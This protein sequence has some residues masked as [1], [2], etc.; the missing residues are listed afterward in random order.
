MPALGRLVQHDP[1]SRDFPA[2]R[3][4]LR[5]TVHKRHA[6]PFNQGAL[7]SCTAHAAFGLMVTEPF[8][9]PGFPHAEKDMIR[10]YEWQTVHDGLPGTYPPDD[11]GSSGLAAA[12][13]LKSRGWISSY[14]HAFGVQ[15]A[16]EALVVAPVIVGVNWYSSFD[17]PD[18]SGFVSISGQVRGGHEF[19]LVGLSVET[20]TVQACNSWGASWGDR[21]FFSFSWADLDRLLQE[22]GDVTTVTV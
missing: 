20:E 12:K 2:A 17:S 15:H 6:R 8:W 21:G 10:A 19:E 22:Q 9:K 14:A 3:S 5:T 1:R 18:G 13:Y 7:G 4:A 11:T 16:L